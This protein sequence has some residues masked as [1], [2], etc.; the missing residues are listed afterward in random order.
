M[1]E[2]LYEVVFPNG[3]KASIYARGLAVTY[4]AQEGK[5]RR[6]GGENW[7]FWAIDM[8]VELSAEYRDKLGTGRQIEE[9]RKLE[10][11]QVA[12]W[13]MGP[14][15]CLGFGD[16]MQLFEDDEARK[17]R[18]EFV[19]GFLAR[20]TQEDWERA[21]LLPR[22]EMCEPCLNALMQRG[23]DVLHMQQTTG[24]SYQRAHLAAQAYREILCARCAD[25]ALQKKPGAGDDS[26]ESGGPRQPSRGQTP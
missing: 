10:L 7:G 14:D 6:A 15:E 8:D 1:S 4:G 17:E 12:A 16:L 18:G 19:R 20:Q 2:R 9:A 24:V 26:K 25:I 11:K 3:E 23:Q 22:G 13:L 21:E 5:R